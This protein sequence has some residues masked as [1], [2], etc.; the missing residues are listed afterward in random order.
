ML[1][2]SL[3]LSAAAGVNAILGGEVN[4]VMV[5]ET[6]FFCADA[7]TFGG[8][9]FGQAGYFCPEKEV[10]ARLDAK[11]NLDRNFPFDCIGMEKKYGFKSR[12]RSSG[13]EP[14]KCPVGEVTANSKPDA[15]EAFRA[16]GAGSEIVQW[17][18][19]EKQIKAAAP[20]KSQ[21]ECAKDGREIFAK[22]QAESGGFTECNKKAVAAIK[23]CRGLQ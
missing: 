21:Q 3:L 1:T 4:S 19:I 16:P 22:C 13:E 11:G 17:A 5:T 23:S 6:S 10:I 7:C 9:Y 15:C 18:D 8:V 14:R 2:L 20:P 12:Q